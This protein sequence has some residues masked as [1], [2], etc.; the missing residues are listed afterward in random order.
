MDREEECVCCHEIEQVAHKNQE[1]IEYTKPILPYDCITDNPGFRTVCLDR[2]VLR[3]AW[4]DFNIICLEQI[5]FTLLRQASINML[6][7]LINLFLSLF[8]LVLNETP[9]V[10]REE[11]S[12]FLVTVTTAK[13]NGYHMSMKN[14]K[15]LRTWRVCRC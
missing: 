1:V 9:R 6:T 4:L 15:T 12:K 2:C 13:I 14:T 8:S 11:E 10:S 7:E 3:A 5:V